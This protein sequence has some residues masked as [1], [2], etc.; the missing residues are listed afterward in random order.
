MQNLPKLSDAELECARRHNAHGLVAEINQHALNLAATYSDDPGL[1][2]AFDAAYREGGEFTKALQELCTQVL[3]SGT[4]ATVPNDLVVQI[5][6]VAIR[7]FGNQAAHEV[8]WE[9]N[10]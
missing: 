5:E 2:A 7:R 3:L 10:K 6:R 9:N 1:M 4:S 8:H